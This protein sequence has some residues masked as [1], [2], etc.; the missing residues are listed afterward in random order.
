MTRRQATIEIWLKLHRPGKINNKG[1][2]PLELSTVHGSAIH[3]SALQ[4]I[5]MVEDMVGTCVKT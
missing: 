5:Y 1:G 4:S 2:I 3:G